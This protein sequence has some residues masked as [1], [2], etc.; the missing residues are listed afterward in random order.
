MKETPMLAMRIAHLKNGQ[1]FIVK[2]AEERIEA[3]KAIKTLT[4]S[5][6]LLHTVKTM[7]C[8]SGFKI[9]AI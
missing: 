7:T 3:C 8:S 6:T 4:E 9:Y 5:G 1:S 2:T